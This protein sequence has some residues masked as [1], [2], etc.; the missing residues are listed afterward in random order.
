MLELT[1]PTIK[2]TICDPACGTCGFLVNA[3]EYIRDN[4]PEVLSNKKERDHFN[5]SMFNGYDF[6]NTMLRIGNMNMLLHGVDNPNINYRDSLRQDFTLEEEK[7]SLIL[8]N[9]PFKGSLDIDSTSK[10]LLKILNPHSAEIS[11]PLTWQSKLSPHS[12]HNSSK[13]PLTNVGFLVY[14][15]PKFSKIGGNTGVKYRNL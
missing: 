10:D 6:D 4:Y 2:E 11:A 13:I 1:A 15:T 8:A 12:L 5:R 3:G 9:P 14:C 7:Y